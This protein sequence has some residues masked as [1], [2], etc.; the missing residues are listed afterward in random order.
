MYL[1]KKGQEQNIITI[2]EDTTDSV[3][4][5][6]EILEYNSESDNTIQIDRSNFG[7]NE[8]FTNSVITMNADVLDI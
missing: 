7:E 1:L 8:I 6:V 5:P 3:A 4:A 2:E